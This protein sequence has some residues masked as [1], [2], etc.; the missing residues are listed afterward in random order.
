MASPILQLRTVVCSFLEAATSHPNLSFSYA[1]R[2]APLWPALRT[3]TSRSFAARTPT[4]NGL[5]GSQANVDVETSE[6]VHPQRRA[7]RIFAARVERALVEA[8]NYDMRLRSGL[9]ESYGFTVHAVRVTGDR[10]HATVLWD[11]R[12]HPPSLTD[13]CSLTLKRY[14]QLIR[15][16]LAKA[17]QAREVPILKWRHMALDEHDQH[18]L[19]LIQQIE[20][21]RELERGSPAGEKC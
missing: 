15:M 21:E 5:R 3:Y 8:I 13:T 7:Q 12:R 6:S 20:R 10:L 1:Y 19:T 16:R 4:D 14:E 9:V 11:C 2:E 17:L 18:S